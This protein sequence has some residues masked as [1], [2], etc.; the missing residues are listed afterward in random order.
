MRRHA[1]AAA[2][3]LIL[4]AIGIRSL[5]VSAQVQDI[6]R[7]PKV[8][9]DYI[10]PRSPRSVGSYERLKKRQVLE[11]VSQFL[12]PLRLPTTLRLRTKTCNDNNAFYDPK[13]WALIVC[14]E[15]YENLVAIAPKTTSK[16]G[17]TRR[18]VIVGGF[19]DALFH[20]LG[21]A[22]FD[23]FDIPMF[24]REEDAADQMSAFLMMQFGREVATMTIRGNAFTYL[25][26]PNFSIRTQFADTHGTA[27]QRFYNY[28]CLGYGGD[29][30][31]FQSYVDSGVLPKERAVL[32]PREYRQVERAFAKTIFPHID[33]DLMKR[34]QAKQWLRSTDGNL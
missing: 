13:E 11:E 8:T 25:D 33:R 3:V 4:A 6:P 24:G 22:L 10:E 16:D 9:V 23:I 1:I 29:A 17:Y 12:S 21:H 32:C 15:Y 28:I 26:M 19:V 14:Y 20:E 5:P 30:A 2:L 18:E 34:V 7:N 27:S 31:A